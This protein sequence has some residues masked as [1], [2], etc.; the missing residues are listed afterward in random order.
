MKTTAKLLSVGKGK[1]IMEAVLLLALTLA[2][3]GRVA[4]AKWIDV[5][6]VYLVNPSFDGND[7]TTGWLGTPWGAANPHENAEHYEKMFNSY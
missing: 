1:K 6:S 4:A 5:T 2:G 3:A 7:R